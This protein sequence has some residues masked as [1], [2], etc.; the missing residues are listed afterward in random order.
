MNKAAT[1][2]LGFTLSKIPAPIEHK[3][4]NN[5]SIAPSDFVYLQ[6]F[7]RNICWTKGIRTWLSFRLVK[8]KFRSYIINNFANASIQLR[9]DKTKC[10]HKGKYAYPLLSRL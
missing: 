1:L 10:F 5:K 4:A 6:T 9:F 3:F 7:P 2:F 8:F